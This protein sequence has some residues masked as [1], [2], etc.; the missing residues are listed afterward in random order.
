MTD[1]KARA[2]ME[3]NGIKDEDL[4][5]QLAQQQNPQEEMME[6]GPEQNYQ[7]SNSRLQVYL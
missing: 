5:P 6:A 7:E 1:A 4:I 3:A 2:Y